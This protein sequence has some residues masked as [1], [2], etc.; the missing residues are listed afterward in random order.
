MWAGIRTKAGGGCDLPKMVN[1]WTSLDVQGTDSSSACIQLLPGSHKSTAAGR[2]QKIR[3]HRE[4]DPGNV[5]QFSATVNPAERA[6]AVSAELAFGESL[7]FSGLV[8]H[9]SNCNLSDRARIGLV[10]RYTVCDFTLE[11]CESGTTPPRMLGAIQYVPSPVPL[12]GK[13]AQKSKL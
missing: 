10:M 4:R 7:L 11:Q 2:D 3:A 8:V 6:A 9:G 1:V 5:L 12:A 13:C